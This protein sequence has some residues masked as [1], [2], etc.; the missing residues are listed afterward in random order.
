[1]AGISK[2]GVTLLK[3]CVIFLTFFHNFGY[4]Q[5]LD[6]PE[7]V[8]ANE[9]FTIS[10]EL[11]GEDISKNASTFSFEFFTTPRIEIKQGP[12]ISKSTSISIMNGKRT[13]SYSTKF[14][15]VAFA[16]ESGPFVVD[17][18]R[19]N[20]P[21]NNLSKI[22]TSEPPQTNNAITTDLP[23]EN[24]AISSIGRRTDNLDVHKYISKSG[25]VSNITGWCYNVTTDKW[26]GNKGFIH[27][28]KGV[29]SPALVSPVCY[30]LQMCKYS[31]ANRNC[32]V[33]KW[34]GVSSLDLSSYKYFIFSE[35]QYKAF[36]SL[37]SNGV[38]EE[39]GY[40]IPFDRPTSDNQE[41]K[42]VLDIHSLVKF[43][44]RMDDGNVVRFNFDE[45]DR[46][47]SKT[48]DGIVDFSVESDK[49]TMQGYFEVT[50][51]DWK[52]LFK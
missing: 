25:V 44:A 28:I 36:C 49:Y 41:I 45:Y 24:K 11:E 26:S 37:T 8:N 32:Y 46:T 6:A 15:Y 39:V 18:I 29:G 10:F 2:H 43:A 42:E 23:K 27:S 30:S 19:L 9:E 47:I 12:T 33:L 40:T 52:I 16:V 4:A 14:T 5:S 50:F 7:R 13:V 1:M 35:D 38:L 31:D 48:N 51:S 20:C 22:R 17:S 34:K 21:S 3:L